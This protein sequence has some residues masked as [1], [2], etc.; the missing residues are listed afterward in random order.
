MKGEWT[1]YSEYD[2]GF[3]EKFLLLPEPSVHYYFQVLKEIPWEEGKLG[4]RTGVL[5]L[6]LQGK[7]LNELSFEQSLIEELYATSVDGLKEYSE[8]SIEID[9]LVHNRFPFHV[10]QYQMSGFFMGYIYDSFDWLTQKQNQSNVGLV[11]FMPHWF[12][13]L[14]YLKW[15]GFTKGGMRKCILELFTV[16]QHYIPEHKSNPAAA[17]KQLFVDEFKRCVLEHGLVKPELIE[18]WQEASENTE[19]KWVE[20]IYES[21]KKDDPEA[22]LS[23]ES[24]AF[25]P[26][27]IRDNKSIDNPCEKIVSIL[28]SNNFVDANDV[29]SVK[30]IELTHLLTPEC[31]AEYRSFGIN[32]VEG[33]LTRIKLND[34]FVGTDKAE[35]YFDI[36]K[37]TNLPNET[38]TEVPRVWLLERPD[39]HYVT[40]I[41]R[42]YCANRSYLVD[43][44]KYETGYQLVRYFGYTFDPIRPR[45]LPV[46]PGD[47]AKY[48]ELMV[49]PFYNCDYL[50]F[51][52]GTTAFLINAND[53][54]VY[55]N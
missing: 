49:Q 27:C 38:A 15:K 41:A 3:S 4:F 28:T 36:I 18:I 6:L 42:K 39:N 45:A 54:Y 35:I 30:R 22:W 50:P 20:H 26:L 32:T 1:L 34:R 37:V 25:T 7:L 17:Q 51:V 33:E 29:F 10:D 12:S 43:A 13:A 40:F 46:E 31:L 53:D 19:E 14:S 2:L 23:Y 21:N 16:I 52:F 48:S 44:L 9:G 5:N 47:F 55:L 24:G 11:Y 8:E